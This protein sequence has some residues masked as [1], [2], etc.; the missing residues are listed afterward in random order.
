[1]GRIAGISLLVGGIGITNIMLATVLERTRE[2]GVRRA[3][4]ARRQDI[5]LQFVAEAFALSAVGGLLGVVLMSNEETKSVSSIVA[6]DVRY[7]DSFG[8][9][10]MFRYFGYPDPNTRFSIFAGK[11][12][13]EG[14]KAEAEYSGH[15]M[16]GGWL[17]LRGHA[18]HEGDPFERFYGIGNNTPS[19]NETNFGSTINGGSVSGGFNFYGPWQVSLAA[20]L[21]QERIGRGGVNSLPQL[22]DPSSGFSTVNGADGGTVVGTRFGLTC[23]TRDRQDIPTEGVF[24][25]AAIEPVD[26]ALGSSGSYVKYGLEAKG[27]VPLRQDKRVIVALH[28]ALDLARRGDGP[29]FDAM[30]SVAPLLLVL[31]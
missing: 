13:K 26:K 1:M 4:G 17:D 24:A 31:S 5:R 28:S 22:R 8:I 23:D 16:F 10:P 15:D 3:V 6:P 2:I 19:A 21:S 20:R 25:G 29:R 12:T 7:N 11:A 9:Y 27:F 14:E 18:L 30:S